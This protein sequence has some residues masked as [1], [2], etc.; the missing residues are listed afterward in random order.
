[1]EENVQKSFIFNIKK[2]DTQENPGM[3]QLISQLGCISGKDGSV[4]FH[5]NLVIIPLF[6]NRCLGQIP[7]CK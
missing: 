6:M 2:F 1:L 4:P 7:K 3:E 5:P